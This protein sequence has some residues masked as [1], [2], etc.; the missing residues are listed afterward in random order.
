MINYLYKE[1]IVAII[2]KIKEIIESTLAISSVKN[3]HIYLYKGP[4]SAY[5]FADGL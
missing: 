3:R 5:P 4:N 1:I 2:D